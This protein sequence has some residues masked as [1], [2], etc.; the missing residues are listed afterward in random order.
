MDGDLSARQE[1]ILA[2]ILH[3]LKTRGYAPSIREI[4]AAADLA[5]PSSV[6]YHLGQLE[7]MGYLRRDPTLPR[8]M[9]VLW[10]AE[11]DL[12]RK[13]APTRTVPLVGEI[14][15][16][17][18]LVAE[19]RVEELYRLPEDLVG[20]GDLFMLRVRGDSMVDAGILDHDL[21]VVRSQP[22]VAQ[23]E[24][25]AALVDGEATVKTFRRTRSGEVFLDPAN[26]AYEPIPVPPGDTSAVMGKVVTVLRRV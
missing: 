26:A 2:A 20:D 6:H 24:L 7:Q 12:H 9:E 5:S 13:P 21:V 17:S 8:A 4:G 15:A 16:G 3:S 25:C 23:G 1:R 19:E 11:T 10:D 18:P 22:E 14:A